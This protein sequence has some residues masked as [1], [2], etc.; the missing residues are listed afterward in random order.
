[1]GNTYMERAGSLGSA[2]VPCESPDPKVATAVMG[3]S[4]VKFPPGSNS[5]RPAETE[6]NAGGKRVKQCL[7]QSFFKPTAPNQTEKKVVSVGS[8]STYD[9]NF[10]KRH[11]H[12]D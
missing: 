11:A 1:M 2:K 6:F 7:L 8:S 9:R 12:T 3:G 10:L 5:K 4:N